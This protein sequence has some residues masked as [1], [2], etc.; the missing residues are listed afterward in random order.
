MHIDHFLK[1][2][3]QWQSHSPVLCR[4]V[5]TICE[6]EIDVDESIVVLTIAEHVAWCDSIAVEMFILRTDYHSG[7]YIHIW[8]NFSAW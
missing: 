6:V 7:T 1:D 4:F 5:R 8:P 2:V 3:D